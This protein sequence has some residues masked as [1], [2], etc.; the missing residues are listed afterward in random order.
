[1]KLYD[2]DDYRFANAVC[3]DL[4]KAIKELDELGGLI[5]QSL[6]M[7]K[8][9]KTYKDV[10]DSCESLTSSYGQIHESIS[11]LKAHLDYYTKIKNS[12]GNPDNVERF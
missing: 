11:S 3:E 6:K 2:L 7:L 12:K 8:Y 4:P 10:N 5:Y 9:M 1:M